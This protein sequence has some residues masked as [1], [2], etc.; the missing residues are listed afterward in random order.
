MLVR[1]RLP[2]SSRISIKCPAEEGRGVEDGVNLPSGF[3]HLLAGARMYTTK[4]PV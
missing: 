4:G 1:A 3:P 2:W